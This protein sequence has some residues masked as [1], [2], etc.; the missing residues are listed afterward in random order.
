MKVEGSQPN[1][2]ERLL[3]REITEPSVVIVDP[4]KLRR[5]CIARVLEQWSSSEGL[6]VTSVAPVGL[7]SESESKADCRLVVLSIGG[8]SVGEAELTQTIECIL[9]VFP[10]APLVVMSDRDEPAEVLAAFKAG[11]MGFIPSS[12]DPQI[13]LRAFTFILG[14]GSYFPPSALTA[15]DSCPPLQKAELPID[16]GGAGGGSMTSN[17]G[18]TETHSRKL[19]ARQ[20]DVVKLLRNGLPNKVIARHLGMTEATVK[21]HVR[22]IM[23][24][25]GANNR[26]QVALC[27]TSFSESTSTPRKLED[28]VKH[29]ATPR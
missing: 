21:V 11:A 12:L 8:K 16:R 13:A 22:Q 9:S 26:T 5:S 7:P 18:A 27:L 24:K 14:G 29:A 17:F 19:T 4:L 28:S 20:Q 2:E 3:G 25:L 15:T 23:R 10:D 1:K 6:I